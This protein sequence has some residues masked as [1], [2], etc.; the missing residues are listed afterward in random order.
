[1]ESKLLSLNELNNTFLSLKTHESSG[2]DDVSFNIIK[3]MF[4]GALRIFNLS[5]SASS[6]KRGHSR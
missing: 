5:I 2:V 6:S 1:M 3:K 4:W